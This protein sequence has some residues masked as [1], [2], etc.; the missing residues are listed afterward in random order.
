[1]GNFNIVLDFAK[2]KCFNV[3]FIHLIL[4]LSFKICRRTSPVAQ[5]VSARYLYVSTR[6]LGNA[7][8]VSSNL[9]WR[10]IFFTLYYLYLM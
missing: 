5:L 1:M 8:V 4:L 10:R 3:I 2:K 9:T 7:G 6:M